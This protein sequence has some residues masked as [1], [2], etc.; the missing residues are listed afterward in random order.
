MSFFPM[1]NFP[2]VPSMAQDAQD[3]VEDMLTDAR[4]NA[5]KL[6]EDTRTTLVALSEASFPSDLPKPP[7]PPTVT[8]TFSAEIGFSPGDTAD[9]GTI[10][11][12]DPQ[13]FTA[14]AITVP[15]IL[16][17]LPTYQSLGLRVEIPNPPTADPVTMPT[18]PVLNEPGALPSEPAKNYGDLPT[19]DTITL[20]TFVAPTLEPFTDQPPTFSAAVPGSVIAW[21][22][23]T[24]QAK[25]ANQVQ[26]A[27]EQMLAGG[28]GLP[29]AVETAIWE[30]G[31]DR[32]AQEAAALVAQAKDEWEAKGYTL[33]PGALAG[34]VIAA[35]NAGLDKN[36][37]ASRDVSIKQAE[38]E[39][40]NRQFAV[41]QGIAFENLWVQIFLQVTQRSFEIAKASAELR[42]AI[43]NAEV[44]AFDV[45]AKIYAAKIERY[46]AGLQFALSQIEAY[47]AQIEAERVKAEVNKERIAAFTAKVQAYQAEVE[48]YRAL[49]QAV[50]AK[51]EFEKNRVEIFRAQIEGV[52][53]QVNAKRAE[54]EGYAA[55]VQGEV[56]KATAEEANSRAFVAQITG[57]TAA[58]DLAIKQ[59]DVNLAVSG[60]KMQVHLAEL[61]RLG[62]LAQLQLA[63]IQAAGA[64]YEAETRRAS[65]QYE[66]DKGADQLNM[67]AV[68]ETGR[69]LVAKYSADLQAWQAQVQQITSFADINA[70]SIAAVGQ[71]QATLSAGAL[72]GTSVS[73]N[74]SGQ[75]SRG[76]NAQQS[77]SYSEQKSESTSESNTY[78]V[79]HNYNHDEE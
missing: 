19:L 79:N 9:L 21:S 65:A 17:D 52:V 39:Q 48:A 37:E 14:D 72:A 60:Q 58:K 32:V 4:D 57:A 46:K 18:T 10:S 34:R 1:P 77:Q 20:P 71:I 51:F 36:A 54:F 25:V 61:Q 73:A 56:S 63:R 53:A 70:R 23:P 47:K 42:I 16:G 7:A 45:A 22:E 38:L 41:Q 43:F 78:S 44:A 11:V 76:E 3:F 12:Q 8:T 75:V 33:P 49:V 55:R 5:T 13:P 74:F 64:A 68:I 66:A 69:T 28:T 67:Q 24:Y 62:Q 6:V 2:S 26:A 35:R 50:Q 30:R 31:R 59:T 15:N 27:I 40:A 29:T